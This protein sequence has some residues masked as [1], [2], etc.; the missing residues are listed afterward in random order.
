MSLDLRDCID[1]TSGMSSSAA[2][3]VGAT[4]GQSPRRIIRPRDH[5][6]PFPRAHSACS[7]AGRE[8]SDAA[9]TLGPRTDEDGNNHLI[10]SPCPRLQRQ[11]PPA[12]IATSS[13]EERKAPWAW[14]IL[15]SRCCLGCRSTKS[16]LAGTVVIGGA[17][18][19]AS[20]QKIFNK[21]NFL[22]ALPEQARYRKWLHKHAQCSSAAPT[23]DATRLVESPSVAPPAR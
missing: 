13:A 14:R 3:Y 23:N 6:V 22:V 4:P 8:R 21:H 16:E 15:Q 5:A 10:C 2:H 7:T 19:S 20:V 9:V 18:R 1:R 11:P 17:V 12:R